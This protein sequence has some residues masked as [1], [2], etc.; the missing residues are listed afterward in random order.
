MHGGNPKLL[1]LFVPQC[2]QFPINFRE[3]PHMSDQAMTLYIPMQYLPKSHICEV[4]CSID[5]LKEA[6]LIMVYLSPNRPKAS[7]LQPACMS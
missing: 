2:R 4:S 5:A 6:I 7:N 3:S 1:C